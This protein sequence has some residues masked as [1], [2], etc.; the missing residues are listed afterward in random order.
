V[1]I[2]GEPSLL[3]R[4][5]DRG[6]VGKM[7]S[8]MRTRH[9]LRIGAPTRAIAVFLVVGLAGGVYGEGPGLQLYNDWEITE[10]TPLLSEDGALAAWGWARHPLMQFDRAAIPKA[11]KPRYKE[12]DFYSVSGPDCYMDVTLANIS[13]AVLASVS[14]VD[15]A[16]KEMSTNFQLEPAA[17]ALVLPPDPYESVSYDRAGRRVS[18]HFS[19]NV[20]TLRFDFPETW[21]VGPRIRG[22]M[23]ILD[24]PTEEQ[25]AT[26]FPFETPGEFFYTNKLVALPASGSVEVSGTAHSFQ[27]GRSFAV[28]DWGRGVWP[29]E[30]AWGWAV[31]AGMAD[32]KRVGFNIGFGDEDNSRASGNSVVVDGVLHKLGTIDWTWNK[33]DVMQPWRFKGKDGRFD[34]VLEPS[35][36]QSGEVDLGQFASELDKVHGA[37]SGRIVLDDGTVLEAKGLL[38][39]A[40]HA[41]QRW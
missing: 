18:F 31:G 35:F 12:W 9:V 25:L 3:S 38:A 21:L 39:F 40:E 24:D 7:E 28:L 34:V 37:A 6:G 14:F 26:A 19:D 36:D 32:G 17:D 23:R 33:G 27:P 20:R 22:E 13:W 10:K 16:T 41:I 1:E 29:A 2:T 8:H 15:Y 11:S 30:F 4:D 5:T